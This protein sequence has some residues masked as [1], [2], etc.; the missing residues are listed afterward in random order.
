M[1]LRFGLLL[2]IFACAFAQKP[3]PK[4]AAQPQPDPEARWVCHIGSYHDCHCPAMVAETQENGVKHCEE[5]TAN[6]KA[7]NECLSKLPSNCDIIQQ[8]DKEHPEHTCKRTCSH[9]RCQCWDG[10]ACAGPSLT[11]QQQLEDSEEWHN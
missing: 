11:E 7:Y 2:L 3:K 5:T 6:A 1:K 8:P 9:A 10:P 4:S